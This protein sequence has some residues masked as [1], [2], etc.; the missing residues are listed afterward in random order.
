[1]QFTLRENTFGGFL[2][3][4]R[5]N[6]THTDPH[7]L[8]R[9]AR[10]DIYN[11][12][13]VGI[14]LNLRIIICLAVQ[15][16]KRDDLTGDEIEQNFYFCSH[17]ERV[18]SRHQIYDAIDRC[19]TYILNTIEQFTRNGSGWVIKQILFVDVHIGR[20]R[21]FRGGCKK[22]VK[23]P[24]EIKRKKAVLTIR[25]TDD[26]CFVYCVAAKLYPAKHNA[27]NPSSYK[28][29]L[30]NFNLRKL[31]FPIDKIGIKVFESNNKLR[32][33]VFGYE[34]KLRIIYPIYFSKQNTEFIDIDLLL[35]KGH[36]FLIKRFNA[37]M[38][39]KKSINY[40]CKKCLTGFA[41]RE[42]LA[43][44]QT[45]CVLNKPQRVSVAQNL[46]IK[47]K[48]LSKMVRH[49][50]CVY[51]DFEALK[52]KVSSA[53]PNPSVTYRFPV[54]IHEPVSYTILVIGGEDAILFH[55]HYRGLDAVDQFLITLR[56]VSETLLKKMHVNKP[57]HVGGIYYDPDVCHICKKGF[58]E[59]EIKCL[60]HDHLTGTVR[61]MAHQACNINYRNTF[62]IPV[63]IHNCRNYDSHFILKKMSKKFAENI[64]LIPCTVEKFM[65]FT[66]DSLRFIDS[67]QFLDT[68]LET[69]VANLS[70]S[71]HDFKIFDKFFMKNGDIKHLLKRKGIFPYSYFDSIEK[72]KEKKLPSQQNFFNVL[73]NSSISKEDYE[74]ARIVYNS[75]NCQNLGDYLELYQNND[76]VLLAEVFQSFRRMSLENFEL[77]PVYFITSAQLTY[78]AGLK[79]TKAELDLL[80]HV[81]T[82]LWLEN[83]IRGGIC[84]LSKRY[85]RANNPLIPDTYN[86][87]E[88]N[89]YILPLDV[90]NLYGS[91][92]I[93]YLPQGNFAWL[94][95]EEVNAF[96]VFDYNAESNAGFFVECDIEYPSNIHDLTNELPLAVEHLMINY[97]MLSEYSK[98]LC[99]EFDLKNT[100]PS[101]KLTPNCFSKKNYVVH[102]LNLKFYLNMGMRLIKIHRVLSFTQ[103]SWLRPYIMRLHEKRIS[104]K[105]TFSKSFYKKMIN[106]F[107][108]RLMLNVRSRCTR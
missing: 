73:T 9:D 37:L 94:S 19:F 26:R 65:M 5:S 81:D 61:G 8:V 64:Q 39:Y 54:E 18:L 84:Y 99:K 56:Y 2:R 92:M 11:L 108:G 82:Y 53:L 67:F 21:G 86:Q 97:E 85:V 32:I 59:K 93:Q 28:K 10:R 98:K 100:L 29:C 1:M 34:E 52:C 63:V 101:R 69:L 43:S 25:C 14:V 57:P 103:S 49:P 31:K 4:F 3:S 7:A 22:N 79:I 70:S 33:N 41:R 62:F 71:E 87:N 74:H 88:L 50:F 90:T 89:S 17:A 105:D 76:V 104:A 75:F 106:S 15:F 96:N 30:P 78:N 51:A 13:N 47:F 16:V 35:F 38:N 72:L 95:E 12:L 6:V 80:K 42:S 55:E 45:L 58:K 66:L 48:D 107:F 20:Y 44:H 102:Y 68:S 40:F 27:G 46:I 77:D 60:E 83:Q 91:V 23:L 24:E 36:Y